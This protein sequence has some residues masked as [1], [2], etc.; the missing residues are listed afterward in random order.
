MDGAILRLGVPH[1]RL[2]CEMTSKTTREQALVF[3]QMFA[4]RSE[5]FVLVTSPTHMARSMS[6]I[7][8]GGPQPDCV[9][10]GV[11]IRRGASGVLDAGRQRPHGVGRRRL[12]CRREVVLLEARVAVEVAPRPSD[13]GV[14]AGAGRPVHLPGLNGVRAIAAVAVV[15]SHLRLRLGDFG[16]PQQ[17]GLLLAQYGVTA[18]FALSGF[19]IT[20]LLLKEREATQHIDVRRF[21]MRRILRIWPLYYLYLAVTTLVLVNAFPRGLPGSVVL[22]VV[23]LPNVPFIRGNSLP[24]LDHYWSLGVEEQFYAAWPLILAR[25]KK[26]LPAISGAV[27]LFMV[28]KGAAGYWKYR[29]QVELPVA[30]LLLVNRFDCMLIGAIGGVPGVRRLSAVHAA[31]LAP[32]NAARRVGG[33][34][35]GGD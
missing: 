18:F 32:G 7:S 30:D 21:Y 35:A 20:F 13:T 3:K 1:D 8:S 4:G 14:N 22:Y 19:L 26:P 9:S 33:A 28:A 31:V 29:Y 34:G 15:V 23:L 16:F 24:L 27:M 6:A 5:A 2:V 12:R 10:I 11:A 17:P 25:V